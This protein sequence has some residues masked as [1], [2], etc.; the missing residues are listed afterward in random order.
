MVDLRNRLGFAEVRDLVDQLE[1]PIEIRPAK[2]AQI[3]QEYREHPDQPLLGVE[4]NGEL[5]GIIGLCLQPPHAAI[6]RHIV[7]RRD[8]RGKGIGRQMIHQVCE[9]L[10]LRVIFA[11]TD[12]DAVEFY[13][14]VGFAVERLEETYP[15]TQRFT[16]TLERS[17][18]RAAAG[19]ADQP[20]T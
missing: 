6:I 3:L 14:K 19:D 9:T 2:T 7:V 20:R 5:V 15:G 1:Y 12:R 8:H 16:C 10:L 11:E 18:P 17:V 4:W 13:R